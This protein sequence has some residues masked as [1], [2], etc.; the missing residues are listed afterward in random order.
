M[1][2]DE[3]TKTVEDPDSKLLFCKHPEALPFMKM[4][5]PPEYQINPYTK[6]KMPM[7]EINFIGKYKEL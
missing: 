4:M 3:I 7:G 5:K 2:C 6:T 1:S